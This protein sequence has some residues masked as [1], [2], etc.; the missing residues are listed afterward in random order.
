MLLRWLEFATRSVVVFFLTCRWRWR[1]SVRVK[2]VAASRSFWLSWNALI[3]QCMQWWGALRETIVTVSLST[4]PRLSL[5]WV[6]KWMCWEGHDRHGE[7]GQW[8]R[9]ISW[10][11]VRRPWDNAGIKWHCRSD[12]QFSGNSVQK[13]HWEH[14]KT[15]AAA[16]CNAL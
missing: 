3:A 10:Y 11:L 6:G 15:T 7:G 13:D 14:C 12:G 5:L 8:R 16:H 4:V 1:I 9:L 2:A